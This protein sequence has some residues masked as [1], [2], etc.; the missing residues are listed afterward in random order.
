M[1]SATHTRTTKNTQ[2][3]THTQLGHARA[4]SRTPCITTT[5]RTPCTTTTST[6]T[7]T[8]YTSPMDSRHGGR[9]L[10]RLQSTLYF[11]RPPQTPLP[12]LRPH[13]LP[14]LHATQAAHPALPPHTSTQKPRRCPRP[15]QSRP[16]LATTRLRHLLF[17]TPPPP[18]LPPPHQQQSHTSPPPEPSLLDT[19][20][21]RALAILLG[22]RNQKSDVYFAQFHGRQSLVGREG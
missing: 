12:G 11:T 9:P 19:V 17:H 22:T 21:Q 2:E 5:S 18:T 15:A 3:H 10:P 14:G 4:T 8:I 6:S 7:S 1:W 20:F 16:S 13:L